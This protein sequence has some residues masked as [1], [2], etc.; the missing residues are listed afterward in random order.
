MWRCEEEIILKVS[1]T[2]V[3]DVLTRYFPKLNKDMAADDEEEKIE[4]S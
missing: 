4:L 3:V 1:P 2:N